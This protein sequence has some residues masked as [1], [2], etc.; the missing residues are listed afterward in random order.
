LEK[1]KKQI[2]IGQLKKSSFSSSAIS[3]YFLAKKFHGLVLW[4]V[5]L[6]DAKGIGVAEPIQF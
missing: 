5:E 3:Q 4:L 1:T 2:Q 6:I